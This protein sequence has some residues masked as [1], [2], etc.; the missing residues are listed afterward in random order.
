MTQWGHR[1]TGRLGQTVA[2]C[3]P[4]AEGDLKAPNGFLYDPVFVR[5]PRPMAGIRA[6]GDS[7]MIW[8]GLCQLHM[9]SMAAT[10]LQRGLTF[11][12]PML[13]DLWLA[14]REIASE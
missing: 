6:L 11:W 2:R 4:P 10:L 3:R 12:L 13:P 1:L 7:Q 14:R 9:A 5:C 8:I